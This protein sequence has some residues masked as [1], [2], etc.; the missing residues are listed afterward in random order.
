MTFSECEIGEHNG[1]ICHYYK[2]LPDITVDFIYV[3]GPGTNDVKGSINGIS[4]DNCPT[5]TPLAG[6]LLRIEPSFLPG[7]LIL[8]DG[9]TNNA[10]FFKNNAKRQYVYAH[11]EEQDVSVFELSEPP[12]GKINRS[13][14]DYSL[15]E[16]YYNRLPK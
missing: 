3:D 16:G 15:G 6:D 13:Q 5:R 10:R 2:N 7:T 11:D 9:R 4:F 12:L 8:F 14:I 1:Q